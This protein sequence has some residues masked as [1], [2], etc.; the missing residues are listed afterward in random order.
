MSWYRK[1]DA[2]GFTGRSSLG[3]NDKFV[4]SSMCDSDSGG[5]LAVEEAVLDKVESM[6]RLLILVCRVSSA[7]TEEISP[8]CLAPFL[9]WKGFVAMESMGFENGD[10]S[11]GVREDGE[12]NDCDR[13]RTLGDGVRSGAVV[14]AI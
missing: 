2:W 1:G 7:P 12:S 5:E 4:Q 9:E 11:M 13:M 3:T 8:L 10:W 14:V 6:D